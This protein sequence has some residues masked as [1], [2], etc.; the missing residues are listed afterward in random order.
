MA[1]NI[2]KRKLKS[3]ATSLYLDISHNGKRKRERLETIIYKN[4][5]KAKEKMAFA[6][7]RRA[8]REIEVLKSGFN[9]TPEHIKNV[10]FDDFAGTFKD[11]YRKEDLRII[12]A[13]IDKFKLFVANKNLRVKD[14][15]PLIM[16]NFMNFLKYDANLKPETSHNYWTRFKKVLKD[17]KIRGIIEVMPTED[18]RFENPRKQSELNP[19]NVLDSDELQALLNTHCGNP[20][21]KR[22]F[23]FACYSSLGLKEI[24]KMTWDNIRDGRLVIKRE[25]TGVTINN[26][27][28]P[29][30]MKLIGEPGD[31]KERIFNLQNIT[32]NGVNKSIKVWLKNAKISKHVTFYSAR[33][34]YAVALLMNGAKLKEVRDCMGQK[35]VQSTL[36][37][38]NFTEKLQDEAIDRLPQLTFENE[39]S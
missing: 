23:L 7:E 26:R 25:K 21:V 30:A 4:D 20:E 8:Q 38:L 37:Y 18:I 35:S 36:R 11:E 24:K 6:K 9:S 14:I 34:S 39:T 33:H 12:R 27:L 2:Y 19:K 15:S 17:A 31:P 16:K 22:A 10:R 13:A 28:G 29:T 1:I 32:T 5:P 3:G